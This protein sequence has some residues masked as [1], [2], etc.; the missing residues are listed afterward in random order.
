M[1]TDFVYSVHTIDG[2][3]TFLRPDAFHHW[4]LNPF[5]YYL[6]LYIRNTYLYVFF[7]YIIIIIILYITYPTTQV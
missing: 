6:I 3:F 5:Y 4:S 2:D 1:A 7:F